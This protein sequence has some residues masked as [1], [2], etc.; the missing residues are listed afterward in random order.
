MDTND[1]CITIMQT[2]LKILP[3]KPQ[4]AA[5]LQNKTRILAEK[6]VNE[7]CTSVS[8]RSNILSGLDM[9]ALSKIIFL[10]LNLNICCGHSKEPSL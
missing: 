5:T 7:T 9:S 2:T 8:E 4:Y 3:T 1:C 10:F 6:C